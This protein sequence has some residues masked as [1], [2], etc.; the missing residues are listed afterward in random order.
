MR[1]S[2]LDRS[3]RR[4]YQIRRHQQFQFDPGLNLVRPGFQ[5]VPTA[6]AVRERRD[7][8]FSVCFA[9]LRG[10]ATAR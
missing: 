10:T 6:A 4:T 2:L 8:S 5:N 3:L 9:T 1:A 7:S